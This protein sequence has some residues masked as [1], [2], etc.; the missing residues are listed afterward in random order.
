M[1]FVIMVYGVVEYQKSTD[2]LKFWIEGKG[3]I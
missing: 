2:N 1:F 3:K